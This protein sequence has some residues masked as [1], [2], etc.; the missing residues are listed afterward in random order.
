MKFA[1]L[2]F[3]CA[4]FAS[5]FNPGDCLVTA[6][7]YMHIQFFKKLNPTLDSAVALTR[8]FISGTDLY[9]KFPTDSTVQDLLL[10]LDIHNNST[11]FIWQRTNLYDTLIRVS[12]TLKVGYTIQ[13]KV[14]SPDCGAFS[15]YEN[16]KILKT[17]SGMHIKAFSTSLIKDPTNSDITAYA[18]NYQI[19]Y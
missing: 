10:P 2:I 17:D 15:Y 1:L 11:T 14:I 3:L 16:L 8:I 18:V 6:T 12:D 13:S 5:C 7:N 4:I 19:F 9:L